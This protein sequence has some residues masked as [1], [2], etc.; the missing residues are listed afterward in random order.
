MRIAT[1]TFCSKLLTEIK[2]IFLFPIGESFPEFRNHFSTFNLRQ[3]SQ[4][5]V[6]PHAL[7]HPVVW[8]GDMGFG[9]GVAFAGKD[10][11][12]K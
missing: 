9:R 2:S 12:A 3:E 1:R 5:C 10:A 7:R 4:T 6:L 11:D 8:P